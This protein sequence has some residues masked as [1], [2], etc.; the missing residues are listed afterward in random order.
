MLGKNIKSFKLFESFSITNL[1]VENIIEDIL[2]EIKDDGITFYVGFDKRMATH[3]SLPFESC[4]IILDCYDTT[5]AEIKSG[6]WVNSMNRLVSVLDSEGLS[7]FDEKELTTK[8]IPGKINTIW[9]YS[10]LGNRRFKYEKHF[11]VKN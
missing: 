8:I 7:T 10:F 3:D 9:K 4:R 1:E 5:L 2:K 6:D 11:L